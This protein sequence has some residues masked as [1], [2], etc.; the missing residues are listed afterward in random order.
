MT[1][2]VSVVVP[3]YRRPDALQQCLMA[4]A[5][6]TRPADEVVLVVRDDD[7][8]SL[9]VIDGW[10]ASLPVTSVPP[11]T[12]G[13]VPALTAGLRAASGEVVAWTDDDAQP[14]P[15]W[16]ARIADWF[17]DPQV[18]AVGGPDLPGA[19][20][21]SPTT[22]FGTIS[23]AGKI[24]A[25]RPPYE[26]YI[27]R[28]DHLRGCNMAVRAPVAIPDSALRGDG[29]AN[30]IDICL[31]LRSRGWIMFDTRVAVMHVG[32]E[33]VAED[34]DASE[35]PHVT[36]EAAGTAAFNLAYVFSKHTTGWARRAIMLGYIAGV[37]QGHSLG[38]I[39]GVALGLRTRD[40]HAMALT[41]HVMRNKLAGWRAGRAVRV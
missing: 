6:Q 5:E 24:V 18:V 32:A 36:A 25:G 2:I 8:E 19:P 29:S 30:E 34:G 33:R 40:P 26:P 41:G 21:L 28:V 31:Q 15:D 22:R 14:L 4:L 11:A 1:L 3:T 7:V 27:G 10:R 16:L 35:R 39:R 12:A 9:R 17:A 20:D 37:G 23:Y 13:Y 38:L